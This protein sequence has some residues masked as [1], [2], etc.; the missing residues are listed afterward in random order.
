MKVTFTGSSLIT[1]DLKRELAQ[2]VKDL[3]QLTLQEAKGHTPV[4]TGN[5][6]SKWVKTESKDNFEVANRVPYIER[7]EAGASRKAPKGII[8]PTL[9]AIKGKVK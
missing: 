2:M 6:K 3:G 1:S 7:L 4:K 9:T 8:G 5:A